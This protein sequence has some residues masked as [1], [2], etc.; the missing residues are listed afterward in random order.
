MPRPSRRRAIAPIQRG[1]LA[2]LLVAPLF[3]ATA[4]TQGGPLARSATAAPSAAAAAAAIAVVAAAPSDRA[5]TIATPVTAAAAVVPAAAMA[6]ATD[7]EP[8]VRIPVQYIAL[9]RDGLHLEPVVLEASAATGVALTDHPTREALARA[10]AT[11]VLTARPDRAADGA[12]DGAPDGAADARTLMTAAPS[13]VEVRGVSI[14]GDVATIDVSRALLGVRGSPVREELLAQQLAHTLAEVAG[15]RAV[16][17]TVEGM[18]IGSVWGHVDWSDGIE[19]DHRPVR[20]RPSDRP[21]ST[22]LA[23][24]PRA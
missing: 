2:T 17:L 12:P 14:E 24:G 1:L 23:S 21:G 8:S 4:P 3:V 22:V 6:V 7:L 13:G 10:A 19:P 11:L 18:R 15:T 5:R 16:L 9:G 20:V